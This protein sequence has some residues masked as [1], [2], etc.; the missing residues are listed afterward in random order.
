MNILVTGGAG[1][2]G[3][4]LIYDLLEN[5]KVSYLD[6]YNTANIKNHHSHNNN[7]YREHKGAECSRR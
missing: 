5:H 6:N 4:N 2:I 1:F 3:T 7:T